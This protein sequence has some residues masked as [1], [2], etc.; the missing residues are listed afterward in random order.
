[1]K[2][3]DLKTKHPAASESGYAQSDSLKIVAAFAAIYLI[4]GTTYLAMAI[5][6]QTIPPFMISGARFV[7]AGLLLLGFLI[8]RGVPLPRW[9]QWKWAAVIGTCLMVGGNG[10]VMWG[11]QEIPSGICAVIIAT[12]PLWMTV[13]DWLFYE[14]PRPTWRV[15][16]GLVLGLAGIVLLIGP[17]DLMLGEAVMHLPSLL[18]VICAPIFWSLGSLQSRRVDLPKNVFMATGAEMICGGAVLLVISVFMQEPSQIDWDGVSWN[19]AAAVVYLTIFGSLIALTSYMWLL[20]N[21]VAS[22]VATYTYINPI[23][24]VFLGWLIL[25]EAITSQT[26]LA[27]V[28]IVSAVVMIVSWRQTARPK[29]SDA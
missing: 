15:A 22:R 8:P 17:R 2:P 24:A 27:I 7:F 16:T 29:S 9:R 18:A 5:A 28:V 1:M 6:V 26:F 19:S 13:F 10:L 12:M 14:G 4:W 23:I 11:I 20:K 3:A 25:D 21:A